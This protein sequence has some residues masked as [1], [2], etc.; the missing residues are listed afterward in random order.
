MITDCCVLLLGLELAFYSGVY[1]TSIGATTHFG[2]SSKAWIGISGIVV[3]F[4]EIVGKKEN[5]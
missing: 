5:R 4:G 2:A 1:G 3:G